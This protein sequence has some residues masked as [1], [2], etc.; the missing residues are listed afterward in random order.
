VAGRTVE[1][2]DVP[3]RSGLEDGEALMGTCG[4]CSGCTGPGCG[5]CSSC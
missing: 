4:C 2:A 1:R 3:R 5:C